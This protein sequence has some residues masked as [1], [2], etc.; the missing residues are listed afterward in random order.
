MIS[1]SNSIWF[2]MRLDLISK[3]ANR[4]IYWHWHRLPCAPCLIRIEDEAFG[5]IIEQEMGFSPY[6][7]TG[8]FLV[9]FLE[10]DEAAKFDEWLARAQT[11][12]T[13][14][15]ANP[16]NPIPL[17]QIFEGFMG[18]WASLGTMLNTTVGK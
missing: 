15:S 2:L 8:F 6:L 10:A 16:N 5:D 9:D 18:N 17:M 4:G 7:M 3:G 14:F 12:G 13:S 1:I 11:G